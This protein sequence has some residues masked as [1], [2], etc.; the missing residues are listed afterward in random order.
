MAD[1]YTATWMNRLDQFGTTSLTLLVTHDQ[2]V[3][4]EQR[5][6]KNYH[7]FP[8]PPDSSYL[9][10]RAIE[11]VERIVAEWNAAQEAIPEAPP[12]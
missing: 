12:E 1:T 9:E 5:I 6:E 10:D 4:P 7:S 3:I 8:T 2:G 11:E